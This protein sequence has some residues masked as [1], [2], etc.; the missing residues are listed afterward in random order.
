MGYLK[1][2]KHMNKARDID[3]SNAKERESSLRGTFDFFFFFLSFPKKRLNKAG[4]SDDI[5]VLILSP[6]T[7]HKNIRKTCS[8]CAHKPNYIFGAI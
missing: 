2:S 6:K 8:I 3:M 1:K 5:V 4:F 7:E